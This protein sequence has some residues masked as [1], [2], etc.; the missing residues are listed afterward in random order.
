MECDCG[1]VRLQAMLGV[2]SLTRELG[3]MIH[4]SCVLTSN[5]IT[6]KKYVFYIPNIISIQIGMPR[7]QKW[8]C[9]PT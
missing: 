3:H 2:A 8:A 1:L 9:T 4:D 5:K 6:F 7:M